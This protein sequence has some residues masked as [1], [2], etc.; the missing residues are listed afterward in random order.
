MIRRG[1]LLV[2]LFLISIDMDDAWGQPQREFPVVPGA[3]RLSNAPN[4]DI[5]GAGLV[6]ISELKCAACHRLPEAVGESIHWSAP[7]LRPL[8]DTVG[9]YPSR[10]FRQF[11]E[12]PHSLKPDTL[13]PRFSTVS[14]DVMES[15]AHF[16]ATL[17]VRELPTDRSRPDPALRKRGEEVYHSV[18]CVAC[19]VPVAEPKPVL[20][21]DDP[22][23][24]SVV[25]DYPPPEIP[26][27]SIWGYGPRHYEA[28]VRAGSRAP[29]MDLAD[30]ELFAL[31]AYLHPIRT[32]PDDGWEADPE[33][34]IDGVEAFVSTGCIQCHSEVRAELSELSNL[35][36][37][38]APALDASSDEGCLSEYPRSPAVDYRLTSQQGDA[39]RAALQLPAPRRGAKWT[40]LGTLAAYNCLA[41]H[42]RDGYGGVEA[43]RA[44][45][46]TT[47]VDAD[48]GDEGRIPPP[49]TG[50]G[51][52]LTREALARV[53]SAESSARPYMAAK[54][55]AF[56][57][58]A[59][60]LAD[61][62]IEA[63]KDALG[64]SVD[65]S[66]LALHH[67]NHY[68]RELVG[69]DGFGCISCHDFNGRKSLGIPAVDL[70]LS[71]E[72]LRPEWFAKYLLD[73]GALRPGTRMPS[74]FED[75]KSTYPKL[76]G[77]N[78]QQ[79]IEA[80]WIYLREA[81][82]TRLP[83]GLEDDERYVIVPTDRPVVHRTFMKDVG[84]RAIAVGFPEGV[85]AAFDA[86]ACRFVL[87]WRG[88][89][90]D[91]NATWNDRFAPYIEPLSNEQFRFPDGYF[92][93]DRSFTFRGF[94]LDASGVPTFAYR[95]GN[96]VVQERLSPLSDGTGFR[97]AFRIENA[98]KPMQ[99]RAA[100]GENIAQNAGMYEIDGEWTTKVEGKAVE[101]LIERVSDRE[102]A[103]IFVF[104]P[105]DGEIAFV[106]EVVW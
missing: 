100:T 85:H 33:R 55:P 27:I 77:G 18:G 36:E 29:H 71:P 14:P 22:F 82:R 67:R 94:E 19:H 62:F 78:P 98:T 89:F 15:I 76:F 3:H 86:G 72:R 4:P 75:G 69:Q 92:D 101:A 80:M 30:D 38:T 105:V 28:P 83:A 56:A 21:E 99:F 34:A 51:A 25:V 45:H 7:G 16:V 10:W 9:L 58:D 95:H 41:C 48:L 79:Q 61:L 13:M 39:I 57:L 104:E 65:V 88:G 42:E 96:T 64:P 40:A 43:G 17:A 35:E 59:E 102:A 44:V 73:P 49:L 20:G 50:V 63:D 91:A 11:V 106:Q 87:A 37:L 23:A 26:S 1:I 52:K 54:M 84:A 5:A 8:R 74:Y 12:N 90:L 46:F 81:D 6:L 2:A 66:G 103:L 47:T 31:A 53:L 97:R 70:T 60:R 68:G 24:E 93:G 32:I